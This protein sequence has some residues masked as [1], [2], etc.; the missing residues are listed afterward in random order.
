M[1]E[2]KK[3]EKPIGLT[4]IQFEC[5]ACKTKTYINLDDTPREKMRCPFC[6][7]YTNKI[8][9]F[10]VDINGIGDY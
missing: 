10:E 2:I 7:D 4:L 3:L 5:E 8:R 6:L 9:I 1:T